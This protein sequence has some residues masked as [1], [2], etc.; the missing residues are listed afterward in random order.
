MKTIFIEAQS[1]L[2]LQIFMKELLNPRVE[3]NAQTRRRENNLNETVS[4]TRAMVNCR[5]QRNWFWDCVTNCRR[6]QLTFF[7]DH[8]WLLLLLQIF[9]CSVMTC[10]WW[11]WVKHFIPFHLKQQ[12]Y[13]ANRGEIDSGSFD[14]LAKIESKWNVKIGLKHSCGTF[15]SS[16]F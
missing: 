14:D 10:F 16:R 13:E 3:K 4:A 9:R 8:S 7:R 12:F 6:H 11:Y 1:R 15:P 2:R 5:L